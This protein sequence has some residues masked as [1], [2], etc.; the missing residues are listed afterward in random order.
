MMKLSVSGLNVRKAYI[1]AL[2]NSKNI[3]PPSKYR[4]SESISVSYYSVK[5]HRIQAFLEIYENFMNC[6]I[7]LLTCGINEYKIHLT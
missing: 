7:L 4:L 5:V 2:L 6:K 1:H 3:M